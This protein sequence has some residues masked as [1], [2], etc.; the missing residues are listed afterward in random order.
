[1]SEI[2]MPETQYSMLV[3]VYKKVDPKHLEA[4]LESIFS[5]TYP[6]SQVVLV[7]D[8]ELTDGLWQV[9]CKYERL[10]PDIFE[11]LRL[12]HNVGTGAAA[13]AGIKKC[14]CNIILKTDSD[15]ICRPYRCEEQIRMYE[16]D[17]ELVLT[18]GY[19]REFSDET[20]EEISVKSVPLSHGEILK[21]AKRRNPINNPTI[22]IKKDF[23]I[24]N[25]GFDTSVRCEDYDFVCRMLQAGARAKNS[26]R[27]FLDYRVTED[28]LKRRKNFANTKSFISVRYRNFKRGFCG[29]FDF[30][31]PSAA[32]LVMFVLP[33]GLT[34]KI[35]KKLLR[36]K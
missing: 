11:P 33:S 4:C 10:Y 22:G 13:N 19:I 32:Q 27:I 29:F 36:K 5:Q 21:Y 16:E 6:A 23:A 7:C 31:I 35:Y 17:L 8:G 30:L 12:S 1:M 34:G 15:D 25:G 20:G 3:S 9:V 24:K 28:N 18:G 2:K 26:D 14:R